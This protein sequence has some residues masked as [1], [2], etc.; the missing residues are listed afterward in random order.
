[1]S[2]QGVLQQALRDLSAWVERGIAPP[3]STNYRI[4][5]GRVIVPA[6]AEARK[7]IQPVVDLTVNAADHV[8]IAAGQSASFTGTITV[9]PGTGSVVAADWDFAGTGEF[10]TSSAVRVGARV[11]RVLV[12]HRFDQPGTYFVALRGASQRQGD[13]KTPYARIENL[14]RVRV[15]VR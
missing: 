1:M 11:A 9:P 13:R 2:Y 14:G 7:G 12:T 5:Q 4:D 8:E 10:T 3:A 15:T 6:T